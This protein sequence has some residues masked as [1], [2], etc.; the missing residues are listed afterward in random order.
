M[1][2][3]VAIKMGISVERADSNTSQEIVNYKLIK[4]TQL[5]VF[6]LL[7]LILQVC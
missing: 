2:R 7:Q 3:V 6:D 4:R 5:S 1:P